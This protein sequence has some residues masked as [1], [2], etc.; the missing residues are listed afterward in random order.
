MVLLDTVL[1]DF[2]RKGVINRE[3]VLAFCNDTE[4]VTKSLGGKPEA[5]A[6]MRALYASEGKKKEIE[7]IDLELKELGN[8][9]TAK[10]E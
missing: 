4:E 3:N 5:M 1:V 7:D 2:Y 6:Q 8:G 9:L 10:N